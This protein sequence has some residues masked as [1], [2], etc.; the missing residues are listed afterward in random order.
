MDPHYA[1]AAADIFQ[2]AL[3]YCFIEFL[4][5]SLLFIF[6]PG[7]II[8]Q[9][10]LALVDIVHHKGIEL[11]QLVAEQQ[12]R[13]VAD[14]SLKSP[15][16]LGKNFQ[17]LFSVRIGLVRPD[18]P[19]DEDLARFGRFGRSFVWSR[20]LDEPDML[21]CRR[22]N[23][24]CLHFGRFDIGRCGPGGVCDAGRRHAYKKA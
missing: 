10:R 7:K 23:I 5:G 3:L 15:G 1:F 6:E 9:E 18:V 12:T 24:L 16:L 22:R 14:Y 17:C 13:I 21:F 2:D 8:G 20:S 11:L 19:P 4:G